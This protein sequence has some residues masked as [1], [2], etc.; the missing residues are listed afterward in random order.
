MGLVAPRHVGS[1]W[2]RDRT[3][4][5]CN[6]RQILNHCTTR[7]VSVFLI[8][9]F[10]V[11]VKWYLIV[12]LICMSLITNDTEHLVI[13]LLTIFVS[14]YVKCLFKSFAHS[15]IGLFVFLVLRCKSLAILFC[16]YTM[17]FFFFH[18]FFFGENNNFY[19]ELWDLGALSDYQNSN[20]R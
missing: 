2:I 18:Y 16:I 14:S 8:I 13:C 10:L 3:T 5:P 4:V 19:W 15:L 17:L 7:E 6:G 1:S 20:M 12:V 11:G 9:A